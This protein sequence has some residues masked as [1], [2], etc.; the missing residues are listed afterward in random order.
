MCLLAWC[1][2]PKRTSLSPLGTAGHRP[3]P[4]ENAF[5][6]VAQGPPGFCAGVRSSWLCEW[7]PWLPHRARPRAELTEGSGVHTG[8]RVLAQW[9]PHSRWLCA[10]EEK[11]SQ[12]CKDGRSR[13]PTSHW[14]S[15]LP[16]PQPGSHRSQKPPATSC[17]WTC[18]QH[19]GTHGG[20]T[21]GPRGQAGSDALRTPEE[22]LLPAHSPHSAR[23]AE[24]GPLWPYRPP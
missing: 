22:G 10:P 20:L 23:P 17:C 14:G 24:G 13:D 11:E 15:L 19:S 16:T 21:A 6:S 4:A 18:H 5:T 8:L 9:G 12:A 1:Q 2:L 3:P 7:T